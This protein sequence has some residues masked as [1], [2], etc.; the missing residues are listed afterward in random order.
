MCGLLVGGV[1]IYTGSAG[2]DYCE[3]L[4]WLCGCV[5]GMGWDGMGWDGVFV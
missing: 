3:H 2:A 5:V 4:I 1:Y